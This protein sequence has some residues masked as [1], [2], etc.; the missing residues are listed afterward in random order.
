MHNQR[1]GKHRTGCLIGCYRGICG[2]A[3]SAI[4]EEYRCHAG[5]YPP[6]SLS[7]FFPHAIALQA[8]SSA[9]V[10]SSLSSFSCAST[11]KFWCAESTCRKFCPLSASL[12]PRIRIIFPV[13][14][15]K[16]HLKGRMRSQL[17][18]ITD[19]ATLSYAAVFIRF[20]MRWVTRKPH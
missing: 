1:Q 9:G 16:K 10:T 18:T 8:A 17:P 14:N 6:S 4:F 5:N 15:H 7:L 12:R 3:Y 19:A 2:W 11:R 20:L 13:L